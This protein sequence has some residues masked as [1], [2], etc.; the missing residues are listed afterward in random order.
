MQFWKRHKVHKYRQKVIINFSVVV[1]QSFMEQKKNL[2][3]KGKIRCLCFPGSSVGKESGLQCGR[4]RFNSWVG[5]NPWR[6]KWQPT[7]IFLCGKF[8]GQRSLACFSPMGLPRVRHTQRLNHYCTV[9]IME[10]KKKLMVPYY[11]RVNCDLQSGKVHII[12]QQINNNF[13]HLYN[14]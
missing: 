12:N 3:V 6:R 10:R 11:C 4:L 2:S 9:T 1:R 8:H 5:M 14:S 7:P 13:F